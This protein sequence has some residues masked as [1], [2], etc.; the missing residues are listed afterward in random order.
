MND[1]ISIVDE[2]EEVEEGLEE[3]K[4]TEEESPAFELDFTPQKRESYREESPLDR[5]MQVEVMMTRRESKK[6]S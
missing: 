1:G 5:G 4:K 2:E 6:K 3:E